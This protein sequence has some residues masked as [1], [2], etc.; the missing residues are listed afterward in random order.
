MVGCDLNVIGVCG[1]DWYIGGCRD[2]MDDDSAGVILSVYL[3]RWLALVWIE[4]W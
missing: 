3:I 4:E 2:E 1:W